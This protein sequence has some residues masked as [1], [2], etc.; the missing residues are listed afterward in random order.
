MA[1]LQ[2]LTQTAWLHEAMDLISLIR[3][4]RAPPRRPACGISCATSG[5]FRS[6]AATPSR[7]QTAGWPSACRSRWPRAC[8]G[9][10]PAAGSRRSRAWSSAAWAWQGQPLHFSGMGWFEDAS[11]S[12]I[13]YLADLDDHHKV[14]WQ[15]EALAEL[16]YVDVL[17][18]FDHLN[19]QNY[20]GQKKC[21]A[22]HGTVCLNQAPPRP[23][24]QERCKQEACSCNE[25]PPESG[26]LPIQFGAAFGLE[27][28]R[29]AASRPWIV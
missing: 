19:M 28:K 18:A 10:T 14:P 29:G 5:S 1:A 20:G 11:E 16:G 7:T 4:Q 24:G 6:L 21:F 22:R 25:H 26:H 27:A 8:C 23:Q 9:R 12:T 2:L 15:E 3:L 17:G 13:G